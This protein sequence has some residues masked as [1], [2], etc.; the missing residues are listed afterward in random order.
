MAEQEY[1]DFIYSLSPITVQPWV[2]L[3]RYLFP[4]ITEGVALSHGDFRPANIKVAFDG[5]T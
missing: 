3:Y 1:D 5:N 4:M 2:K